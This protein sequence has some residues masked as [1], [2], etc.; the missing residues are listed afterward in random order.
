MKLGNDAHFS[1]RST[2]ADCGM[3]TRNF[4]NFSMFADNLEAR[5]ERAPYPTRPQLAKAINF[6]LFP[7]T[8]P[9]HRKG[10]KMTP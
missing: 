4:F 5:V 3:P 10:K 8:D 6:Q 9:Q 1:T 2:P 7:S